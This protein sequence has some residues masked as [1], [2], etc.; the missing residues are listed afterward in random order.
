MKYTEDVM[1]IIETY[2]GNDIDLCFYILQ[3]LKK[4]E[5]PVNGLKTFFE[6]VGQHKSKGEFEIPQEIGNEELKKM[7][8]SYS[9]YISMFLKTLV[10]KAHT[11][12]WDKEKFYEYLWNGLNTDLIL[13]NDKIRSF[14][15][16]RY[17]QSDLMPYIEVGTPL[18]MSDEVFSKI[19]NDNRNVINRIK[20]IVAF[21]YSQKTEVASLILNEIMSAKTEEERVVVLAVAFDIVTQNKLNGLTTVLNKVGIEIE[22]TKE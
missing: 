13:E 12:N 19:L 20:H 17:A 1:N 4:K 14:A 9:K 3:V 8:S 21:N 22:Q 2:V 16:L 18:S 15:L 10:E 7:D 6:N 5:N 11:G